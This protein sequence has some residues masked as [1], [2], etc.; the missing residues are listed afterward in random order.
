MTPPAL[1][2]SF[3]GRPGS[4]AGF[5]YLSEPAPKVSRQK[6]SDASSGAYIASVCV[7]IIFPYLL[8]LC[9]AL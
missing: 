4:S 7:V 8:I 9:V 2:W 3:P 6:V 1:D 5:I